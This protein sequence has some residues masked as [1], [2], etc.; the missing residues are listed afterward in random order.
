M[1]EKGEN[2]GKST[3]RVRP[4][5][6]NSQPL[7]SLLRANCPLGVTKPRSPRL[8]R[9]SRWRGL[10]SAQ[11][12]TP[13]DMNNSQSQRLSREERAKASQPDR[14]AAFWQGCGFCL[15][16]RQGPLCLLSTAQD[17]F[18]SSRSRQNIFFLL[19]IFTLGFKNSLLSWVNARRQA[20]L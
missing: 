12:E 1:T 20:N 3:S 7:Q 10:T 13:G 17:C 9:C 8:L 19:K 11:N 5:V 16:N 4:T 18:S 6:P 2:P 15:L 14:S